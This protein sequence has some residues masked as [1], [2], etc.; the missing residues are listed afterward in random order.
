MDAYSVLANSK[1]KELSSPPQSL[2]H[3]DHVVRTAL[4]GYTNL[5]ADHL[6]NPGLVGKLIGVLGHIIRQLNLEFMKSRIEVGDSSEEKERK[7]LIRGRAYDVLLEIAIN[8]LGWEK[9]LVG[10]SDEE[11]AKCLSIIKETLREWENIE[12]DENNGEAPIAQAV[13]QLKIEDMKKVMANNPKRKGMI[14]IMGENIEKRIEKDDLMLSFLDAVEEEIHSNI[15]YIMSKEKMCRFG[16][17]YA[18]GLRWLRRL[19]YVQVSTNPVLAAIAYKDDPKLWEKFK[20]YLR[21]HPE[22]LE[23]ID[24][25]KDELA[26]AATMMALWPNME[27]FRPIALL[28]NYRDGM[29]SYQ[30][31]PNVA[32]SVEGSLKDALKIYSAAQEYFKKYDEYLAWNW[33]IETEKG[34][35][36]IVFKVAGSSSAAIEITRKLESLGIGTNNT[37]TYTVA[38]EARLILA[39]MEGMAKALKKG[40]S[41]TRN[42]ETNMGGR[43]EGH[44]REVVAAT[45]IRQALEKYE[46]KLAALTELAKEL[47]VPVQDPEAPWTAETG[48]GYQ[49]TAKTLDEKIELVSFRAYLRPLVKEPFI[50]FLAKAGIS[51]KTEDKVREFLED[52]E[53][54]IG[55]AGTLVA[56]RVWWIFFSP[57]NKRKWLAYLIRKYGLKPEQAEEILNN[58][59]VLPAS[60]RKPLDTLLT[61]ASN[62]MT[63]TEFPDHQLKVLNVSRKPDF[64]LSK[65][66]NS[67]MLKHDPRIVEKLLQ[68]EDFRKAYELT[69]ELVEVFKEVEINVDG[70]GLN[71]LKPEEWSSFGS[72][73]KTM[74]G[75]TN[76][77]NRFREEVV[78]VAKEVAKEFSR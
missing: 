11:V 60:K 68:L 6:L 63:N 46:D 71:G 5:A 78:K 19:G 69:P 73:V 17:D 14:A 56:Q 52:W 13:I 50:R 54:T 24:K 15:Y 38:Q 61:L 39:K 23:N 64:D 67:I 29:I 22:L 48:W 57:E 10:F 4:L 41:T 1:P 26:M 43:L 77:Y 62:N 32:S 8:L 47:G 30:L 16:N 3:A 42:Y 36:N 58:I 2:D 75:F 21:K 55:Y 66:K 59:D 74:S 37:V 28:L 34:R 31:N 72:A 12:R 51:G 40:I 76:A 25:Q 33:P 65:Y 35:P 9:D 70:F 20:D 18:I 45:L 27:V 44:L 49:V 53:K 7:I